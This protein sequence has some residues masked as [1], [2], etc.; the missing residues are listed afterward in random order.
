MISYYN[1]ELIR[2]KLRSSKLISGI[3]QIELKIFSGIGLYVSN[4]ISLRITSISE[5]IEEELINK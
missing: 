2:Q 1:N 5:K 4:R 3:S